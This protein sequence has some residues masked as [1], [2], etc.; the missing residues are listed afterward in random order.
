MTTR[1]DTESIGVLV[2]EDERHARRRLVRV[3]DGTPGFH[4]VAEASDGREAAQAI[5]ELSPEIALLDIQMPEM[6][7][8]DVVRAL[9]P[10]DVPAVVFVTSY[11]EFAVS[12]FELHAVDY[13]LKPFEDERISAALD[14][15]RKS[16]RDSELDALLERIGHLLDDPDLAGRLE[17]PI[18]DNYLKRI[19][20][21][22][23]DRLVLVPVEEI[24]YIAGAG[25]YV[26][27]HTGERRYT[28]RQTLAYLEENLPPDSFARIHRSTIVNMNGIHDLSHRM[29]GEY[30][31][32]MN[33]GAELKLSRSYRHNFLRLIGKED[34]DG[35]GRNPKQPMS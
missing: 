26:E 32:R 33:S 12:A 29:H 20:I 34:D 14:R 23:G 4:V 10:D 21:R 22:V 5:R 3:V 35:N 7:G 31:V 8:I 6:S 27:I 24:E 30:D 9:G 15:V 18:A 1:S 13:V 19:A 17:S 2:A 11:D 16:I 28:H 25:V